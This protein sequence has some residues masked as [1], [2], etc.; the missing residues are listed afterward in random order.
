MYLQ[1]K[2]LLTWS[3]WE[4]SEIRSLLELAVQAKRQPQ[5]FAQAM[6]QKTLV[7]LFQKT[8]TRTRV[9][10]EVGCT[11]MG[12]HAIF[13]DWMTSNLGLTEIGWEA[14]YLASN[15]HLIM[16]RVKNHKDLEEIA[17]CSRVP[18]INGCDDRHHPCQA[19]SDMLTIRLD[20]GS[21]EGARLCYVGVLNNVANSLLALA[22]VFG[23]HL[24]LVCP[25]RPDEE[26]D[27]MLLTRARE[28]DCLEET[29][30]L[31]RAIQ[32]ADY[33]Y[34]DTWVNMELYG[35]V[36]GNKYGIIRHK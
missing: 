20:R 30:D 15:S 24:T 18:V 29:L 10:F 35:Q 12:G 19:L 32:T 4:P 3:N 5:D 17:R 28:A 25:I 8:S 13:L 21:L 2:D 6:A 34:T 14:A 16:A 9:S 7:M 1:K 22:P 36:I 27:E 11:E 31:S 26:V 23:V 33:I